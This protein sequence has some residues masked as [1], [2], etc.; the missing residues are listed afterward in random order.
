MTQVVGRGSFGIVYKAKMKYYPYSVRAVKRIKKE[1]VKSPADIVKEYSVLTSFDHP[2]IIKIYE[3]F[4]DERN[5]F[6]VLE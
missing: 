4:E 6:L 2:Q 5:F 1:Y 3:T